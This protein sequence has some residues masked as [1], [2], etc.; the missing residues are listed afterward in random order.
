MTRSRPGGRGHAI[1]TGGSSG[2][3]LATAHALAEQGL[4]VSILARGAERLE[5][6]V[7][8]LAPG[9]DATAF[10]PA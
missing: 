8:E 3:G 10:R 6:A 7:A 9:H 1:I 5:R 4:A 2:I